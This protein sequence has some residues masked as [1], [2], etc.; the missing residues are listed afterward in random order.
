MRCLSN[1]NHEQV[2][3]GVTLFARS[4]DFQNARLRNHDFQNARLGNRDF[5]I[6]ARLGNHK[7]ELSYYSL[8][9]RGGV[10]L[11]PLP[12]IFLTTGTNFSNFLLLYI[13]KLSV[14]KSQVYSSIAKRKV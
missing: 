2:Q 7:A 9:I 8:F 10:V 14:K 6:H 11:N 13:F 3:L 12:S 4:H 1:N 5:Y